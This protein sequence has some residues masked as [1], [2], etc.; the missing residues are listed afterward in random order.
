M[1]DGLNEAAFSSLQGQWELLANASAEEFTKL[2]LNI[3]PKIRREA[4]MS[5]RHGDTEDGITWRAYT[6]QVNQPRQG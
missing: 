2:L 3:G 1:L 5:M 4:E 6:L